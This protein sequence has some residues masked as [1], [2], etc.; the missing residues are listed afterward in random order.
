MI[1]INITGPDFNAI[2]YLTE[3][4]HI[5]EDYHLYEDEDNFADN[6]DWPGFALHFNGNRFLTRFP[7]GLI[8]FLAANEDLLVHRYYKEVRIKKE[9]NIHI[10]GKDLEPF[11]DEEV[12][13][14]YKFK[15]WMIYMMFNYELELVIL[16]YL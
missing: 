4:Q 3:L 15:P 6:N 10:N 8:R 1:S 2:D 16:K 7:F 9:L 11:T 13:R 5:P 14:L 12:T